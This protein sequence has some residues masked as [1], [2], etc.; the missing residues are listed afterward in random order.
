M[1]D[2][3]R[4]VATGRPPPLLAVL[5]LLGGLLPPAA[6]GAAHPPRAAHVPTFPAVHELPAT[7]PQIA[8]RS[9]AHPIHLPM[10]LSFPDTLL[11]RNPTHTAARSGESMPGVNSL[12]LVGVVAALVSLWAAIRHSWPTLAGAA[13]QPWRVVGIGGNLL[14]REAE[15]LRRR[16]DKRPLDKYEWMR[17]DP[18]DGADDPEA[19]YAEAEK[20]A[21][22]KGKRRG[23]AAAMEEEEEKEEPSESV[24]GADD[25]FGAPEGAVYDALATNFARYESSLDALFGSEEGALEGGEA[26]Y[27]RF[28]ERAMDEDAPP[29]RVVDSEPYLPLNPVCRVFLANRLL[30]RLR[31]TKFLPAAQAEGQDELLFERPLSSCVRLQVRTGVVVGPD[32]RKTIAE[33]LATPIQ[34]QLLYRVP[35]EQRDVLLCPAVRPSCDGTIL[36][37]VTDVSAAVRQLV[38]Q[39]RAAPY[40]AGCG[41]PHLPA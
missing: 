6:H 21:A 12:I 37:V 28:L 40:C 39:L 23:K 30:Y 7:Q 29:N 22:E 35:K 4:P 32:G 31:R 36:D 24:W 26:R 38:Q 20:L 15:R 34:L 1:T 2:P 19:E 10:S 17:A 11:A 33:D 16:A 9:A 3:R 14:K 8:A 27:Q 25:T 18:E 41:A 13:P 5:L